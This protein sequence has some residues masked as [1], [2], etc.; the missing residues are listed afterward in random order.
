MAI[1]AGYTCGNWLTTAPVSG[2]ST[3]NPMNRGADEARAVRVARNEQVARERR[4][5]GDDRIA[6]DD[7]AALRD[8]DP[9]VDVDARILAADD[10][11]G[12]RAGTATPPSSASASGMHAARPGPP[13]LRAQAAGRSAPPTASAAAISEIRDEQPLEAVAMQRRQRQRPATSD[14]ATL[15]TI[16]Q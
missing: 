13:R 3:K 10:V 1:D 9:G 2:S 7:R 5:A 14:V 15:R 12:R 8:L 4:H 6:D 11:F 16:A